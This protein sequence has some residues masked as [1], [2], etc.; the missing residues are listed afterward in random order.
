MAERS[1]EE[2]EKTTI[3]GLEERSQELGKI[4]A[5]TIDIDVRV[6]EKMIDYQPSNPT[7]QASNSDGHG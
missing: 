5:E 4:T 7:S 1:V 3:P 6:D 2:L